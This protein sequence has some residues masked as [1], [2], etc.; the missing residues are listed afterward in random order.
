MVWKEALGRRSKLSP[1]CSGCSSLSSNEF[2]EPFMAPLPA[3]P[4]PS[5]SS[6]RCRPA[7]SRKFLTFPSGNPLRG[8]R[9]VRRA[10]RGRGAGLGLPLRGGSPGGGSPALPALGR[11]GQ[12][13]AGGAFLPCR[14]IQ[15]LAA[16][17]QQLLEGSRF[18]VGE[19]GDHAEVLHVCGLSSGLNT[20]KRLFSLSM[21]C[22]NCV[23]HRA[24]VPA[25]HMRH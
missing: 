9:R 2:A 12:G 18:S 13:R 19:P 11:A 17:G 25:R 21:G 15:A 3:R 7:S 6:V 10:R 22:C 1:S 20:S 23:Y 16:L 24:A 5:L 14:G 4:V 8:W